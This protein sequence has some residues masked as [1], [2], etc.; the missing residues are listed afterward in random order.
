M[1]NISALDRL[2]SQLQ[3]TGLQQSNI[4]L[5]QIIS[6]LIDS[7]RQSVNLTTV[8]LASL[9]AAVSAAIPTPITQVVLGTPFSIDG[10][11]GLE[12]EIGP[13]GIGT[14]G[15][16]GLIGKNGIGIPGMDGEDG[17]DSAIYPMGSSGPSGLPA[18]AL[19]AHTIAVGNLLLGGYQIEDQVIQTVANEAAVFAYPIPVLGK[20]LFSTAE[21]AIYVCTAI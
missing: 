19:S 13:P 6:Q 10:I 14:R 4:Q 15:I 11:D 1:P 18:H 21:L 17:L 9:N 5:Y 2:K 3:T 16:D 20:V 7:L 8:G 12:G